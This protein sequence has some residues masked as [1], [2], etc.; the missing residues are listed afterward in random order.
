MAYKVFISYA[1]RDSDL[2]S[3]LAQR[4]EKVGSQVFTVQDLA[5]GE[6]WATGINRALE[7]SDEV[8][9]L[10]TDHSVQSQWVMTEVGAAVSLRKR[11]TPIAVGSPQIPSLLQKYQFIK[12]SELPQYIVELQQRAQPAN[13]AK[14]APESSTKGV[15]HVR[16]ASR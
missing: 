8:I 12:Y 13:S 4:L 5:P 9:A 7:N 10:L 3:D 2:A 16:V 15:K 11:I 14:R 1:E 6:D